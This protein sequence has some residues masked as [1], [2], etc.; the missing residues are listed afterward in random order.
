M[1]VLSVP[2]VWPPSLGPDAYSWVKENITNGMVNTA[3]FIL[4]L[5]GEELTAVKGLLDVQNTTVR[6]MEQMPPIEQVSGKVILQLG[7]VDIEATQGQSNQLKLNHALLNLT[8][9]LSDQPI[10]HIEI[11]AEDR[12]RTEVRF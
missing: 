6:Y 9:L 5:K 12:E 8:E 2:D 7:Q 3:H 11:D 10:A 1:P 4:S